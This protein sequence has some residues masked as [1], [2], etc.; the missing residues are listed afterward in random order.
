MANVA[1]AMILAFSFYSR[2]FPPPTWA[3]LSKDTQPSDIK[4]DVQIHFDSSLQ[5]RPSR[6]ESKTDD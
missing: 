4:S 1:L 6:Y 5:I 2:L 3:T